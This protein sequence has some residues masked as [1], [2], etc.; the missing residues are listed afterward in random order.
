MNMIMLLL[1][2]IIIM[3][4]MKIIMVIAIMVI[5]IQRTA[6]MI[7][8][9]FSWEDGRSCPCSPQA[10]FG[11]LRLGSAEKMGDLARA[12]LNRSSGACAWACLE[13]AWGALLGRTLLPE[14]RHQRRSPESNVG[15]GLATKLWSGIAGAHALWHARTGEERVGQHA[16]RE[17]RNQVPHLASLGCARCT[18]TTTTTNNNNNNNNKYNYIYI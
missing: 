12:V 5:I 18:T 1:F 15:P 11:C 4:M 17:A 9:R 13:N 14:R 6:L 2:V 7:E 3:M 10:Q 16:V 8:C